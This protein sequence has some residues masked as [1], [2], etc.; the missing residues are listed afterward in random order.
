MEHSQND[1]FSVVLSGFDSTHQRVLQRAKD[2]G[3]GRRKQFLIG[4]VLYYPGK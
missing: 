1:L 4:P 2:K 3:Q